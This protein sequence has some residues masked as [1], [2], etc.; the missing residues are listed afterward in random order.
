VL[1]ARAERRG[2]GQAVEERA[3]AG[4]LR[5]APRFDLRGVAVLE[6]AVVVD[7][8][9]AVVRVRHGHAGGRRFLRDG[10]GRKKRHRDGENPQEPHALIVSEV[11]KGPDA[12]RS[13][14]QAAKAAARPAS[15]SV[16]SRSR[17]SLAPCLSASERTSQTRDCN[18]RN[19]W[20]RPCRF[21]KSCCG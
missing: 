5:L 17:S 2:A 13:R 4:V 20:R 14:N 6:P 9:D 18:S 16:H 21:R 12:E 3:G 1:D 19:R 11:R 15:I 8:L 10:E 7:D